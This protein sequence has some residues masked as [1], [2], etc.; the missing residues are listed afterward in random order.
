MIGLLALHCVTPKVPAE[1]SAGVV[2]AFVTNDWTT[3]SVIQ[4]VQVLQTFRC[5]SNDACHAFLRI[6]A[7][8]Q[9]LNDRVAFKA[10]REPSRAS[11]QALKLFQC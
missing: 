10:N 11:T 8:N 6:A 2:A 9:R 5:H 7:I 4:F 1:V 3:T